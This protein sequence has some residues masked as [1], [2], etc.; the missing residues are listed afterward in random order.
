MAVTPRRTPGSKT[1][2]WLSGLQLRTSVGRGSIDH[3][4]ADRSRS[5]R[6]WADPDGRRCRP[7]NSGD[8]IDG[9]VRQV[10]LI[11]ATLRATPRPACPTVEGDPRSVHT[12]AGAS[13][14]RASPS[15]RGGRAHRARPARRVG[16]PRSNVQCGVDRERRSE[17]ACMGLGSGL[18]SLMERVSGSSRW[19]PLPLSETVFWLCRSRRVWRRRLL[20]LLSHHV[21]RGSRND[22]SVRG[23]RLSDRRCILLQDWAAASFYGIAL[24]QILQRDPRMPELS[25]GHPPDSVENLEIKTCPVLQHPSQP[26][27]REFSCRSWPLNAGR[28][29]S[30]VSPR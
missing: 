16:S 18:A 17:T 9:L 10:R 14:S 1:P 23:W 29:T 2:S 27:L 24:Y 15:S 28:S 30:S 4:R 5:R 13:G 21:R 3:P 22:Y 7:G 8:R 20:R 26:F 6:R 19:P 12:G 25:A 11:C